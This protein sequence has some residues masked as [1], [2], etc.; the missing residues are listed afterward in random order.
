M[1]ATASE[2]VSYNIKNTLLLSNLSKI[3]ICR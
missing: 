2:M 1:M 3:R